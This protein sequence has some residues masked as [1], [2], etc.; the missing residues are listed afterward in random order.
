MSETRTQGRRWVLSSLDESRQAAIQV[1][2]VAQRKIS[3]FTQDMDPGIYD[4]D[5]FLN[6]AKRLVL[7]KSYARIEVLIAEPARVV[8]GGNRLVALGRRL[9]TYIEFRNVHEDYRDHHEAFL[10]ADDTALLY[11]VDAS[12]WEGIADT[13]EPAVARRYLQLFTEIWEASVVEQELR[14]LHV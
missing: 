1:A 7:A 2:R 11:R 13:H 8:R 10:V 12:R 4:H 5:D 6:A 14:E 3:I 9:N